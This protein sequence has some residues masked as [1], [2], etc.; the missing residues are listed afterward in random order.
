MSLSTNVNTNDTV[1]S[2][3]SNNIPLLV[4]LFTRVLTLFGLLALGRT[5]LTSD[6]VV[7]SLIKLDQSLPDFLRSAEGALVLMQTSTLKINQIKIT[8]LFVLDEYFIQGDFKFGAKANTEQESG[9]VSFIKTDSQQLVLKI[10]F[11][12]GIG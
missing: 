12:R 7:S 6:I 9:V 8:Y 2:I 5:S 1:L 4:F 10:G 11:I 3:V